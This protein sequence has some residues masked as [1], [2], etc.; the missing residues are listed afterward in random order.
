VEQGDE[1]HAWIQCAARER[2]RRQGAVLDLPCSRRQRP[3]HVAA[4]LRS[5]TETE[6]SLPPFFIVYPW[7]LTQAAPPRARTRE[8]SDDNKPPLKGSLL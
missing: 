4:A 8:L 6:A 7:N 5:R 3:Q 1:A 2:L